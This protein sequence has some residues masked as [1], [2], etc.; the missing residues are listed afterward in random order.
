MTRFIG[1]YAGRKMAMVD[2]AVID[3]VDDDILNDLSL[4]P[5]AYG[6]T[7]TFAKDLALMQEQSPMTHVDDIRTPLLLP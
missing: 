3:H 2:A 1:H 5:G 7:L 6:E 4:Y